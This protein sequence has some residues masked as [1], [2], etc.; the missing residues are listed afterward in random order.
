MVNL[1]S[2][3]TEDIEELKEEVESLE[4]NETAQEKPDTEEKPKIASN[5]GKPITT[6]DQNT[7]TKV[8]F[9]SGIFFNLIQH[10]I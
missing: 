10:I 7:V 9:M 5:N 1:R 8:F 4:L 6:A 3:K 2:K